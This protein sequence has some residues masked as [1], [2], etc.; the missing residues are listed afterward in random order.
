VIGSIVMDETVGRCE[1][2]FRMKEG[3]LPDLISMCQGMQSVQ[4]DA[5][6]PGL[7]LDL[8]DDDRLKS[9][10]NHALVLPKL[11]HL[12]EEAVRRAVL[13]DFFTLNPFARPQ[14]RTG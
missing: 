3:S 2:L 7:V 11:H 12:K 13:L 1:A 9:F 8:E 10:P 4:G 14:G 6:F 5:M